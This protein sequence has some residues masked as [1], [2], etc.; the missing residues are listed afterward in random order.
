MSEKK[1]TGLGTGV[2]F[3]NNQPVDIDAR[4]PVKLVAP[5]KPEKVRTTVMLQKKTL[6]AMELL[7]VEARKQGI[8]ATLGDVLEEAVQSLMEKKKLELKDLDQQ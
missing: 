2:F 8:K 5:P 4:G 1:K 7:K 6:A 3:Q